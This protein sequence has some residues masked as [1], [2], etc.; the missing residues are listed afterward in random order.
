MRVS[1]AVTLVSFFILLN[2]ERIQQVYIR[3]GGESLCE[4]GQHG[5]NNPIHAAWTCSFQIEGEFNQTTGRV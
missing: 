3:K 1:V 2:K 5:F 4:I